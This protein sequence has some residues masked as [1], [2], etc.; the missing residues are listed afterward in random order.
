MSA[1]KEASK[2]PALAFLPTTGVSTH[3]HTST[4]DEV[5]DEVL[6]VRR[7]IQQVLSILIAQQTQIADLQK[8]LSTVRVSRTQELA[9]NEAIRKRARFLADAQ[10][11]QKGGERRIASAIRTTLR[12]VT[13]ARA[14]GDVQASQFERAVNLVENWY[15]EGALRR[16]RRATA[17]ATHEV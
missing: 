15:M 10:G 8:S 1:G 5:L 4:G 7:D 6:L 16:I 9:L 12:E 3:S 17:E 11:M 2:A 13:G 14:A